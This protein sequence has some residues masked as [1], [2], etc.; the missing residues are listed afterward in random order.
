MGNKCKQSQKSSCQLID[1]PSYCKK[2]RP[3]ARQLP[4]FV[5]CHHKHSQHVAQSVIH[6]LYLTICLEMEGPT[7]LQLCAKHI[8][9]VLPEFTNKLHIPGRSNSL[10]NTMQIYYRTKEQMG[11][12]SSN[13]RLLTSNKVHHL[14]KPINHHQYWIT[15]SPCIR[16][17]N[18]KYMDRSNQ[19]LSRTGNCMYDLMFRACPL[20]FWQIW[21]LYTILRT[22][23]VNCGQ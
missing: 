16:N 22:S 20:P 9:K 14:L 7:K 12:W 13:F 17:P 15:T 6:H 2:T 23:L 21:H 1:S 10:C 8:P 5:A 18:T 19:I 4:S 11:H 3:K